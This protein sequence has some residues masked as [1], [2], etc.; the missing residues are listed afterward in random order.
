MRSFIGY[1]YSE[2]FNYNMEMVIKRV[3]AYNKK[4][5]I[6]NKNI[7]KVEIKKEL[8]SICL[9]CPHNNINSCTFEKVYKN[10][11]REIFYDICKN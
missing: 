4:Y 11:T 5:S 7:E 8:D 1:G 6:K 2:D 9:K 3:N 10:I